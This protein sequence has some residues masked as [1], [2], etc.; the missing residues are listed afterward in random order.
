MIT[1]WIHILSHLRHPSL[2]K[3]TT[4]ASQIGRGI[5]LQDL[6]CPGHRVRT[7]ARPALAPSNDVSHGALSRRAYTTMKRV[8]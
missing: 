2:D 8:T 7:E 1:L 5:M 4:T 6:H 3:A